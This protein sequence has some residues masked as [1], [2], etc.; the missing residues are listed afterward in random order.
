MPWLI[1]ES[2]VSLRVSNSMS[3]VLE[4]IDPLFYHPSVLTAVGDAAADE[5]RQ[6]LRRDTSEQAF[7]E[8][9]RL[10]QQEQMRTE[11]ATI[12]RRGIVR[13]SIASLLELNEQRRRVAEC[14][15]TRDS[16][17]LQRM[18]ARKHSDKSAIRH[19]RELTLCGLPQWIDAG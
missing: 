5:E 6:A 10:V 3:R 9:A 11:L 15:M 14:E 16:D 2:V 13:K 4:Q 18:R 7:D 1:D 17:R 8:L 19:D 12:A